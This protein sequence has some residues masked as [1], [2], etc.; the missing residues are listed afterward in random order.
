[1]PERVTI[2]KGSVQETLIIPLYGRKLCAEAFP[3]LYDDQAAAEV[4]ERLDYDFSDLDAKAKS[5]FWRFGALEAAM[6][7]LDMQW[8]ISDYLQGHP[9]AAVVD[10]GCGLNQTALPCDNG[11]C[12]LYG[13]DFP[14]IIAVREELIGPQERETLV[15]SDLNDL[16]WMDMIDGSGEAILFAAGVFHYLT[17]KQA[18]ALARAAA[19]HFPGGRLVFDT[20][21]TPGRRLMRSTFKNFGMANYDD[22]LV[23]DDPSALDDWVPGARVSYRGYMLGYNDMR[24]PGVTGLHRL[25]ARLCDGPVGMRIIRFDLPK[26]A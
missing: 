22:C 14:D 3:E 24:S 23:V 18:K 7:Q 21:G 26:R 8:E 11:R 9:N 25:L 19:Q 20:L 5:T 6:R 12:K 4:C 17:R 1:M 2:E 10:M 13:I 16:A 15:A